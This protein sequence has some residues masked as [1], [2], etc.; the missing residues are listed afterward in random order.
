MVWSFPGGRAEHESAVLFLQASLQ[1]KVVSVMKE[2]CSEA[3]ERGSA[4]SAAKERPFDLVWHL[5]PPHSIELSP[6]AICSPYPLINFSTHAWQDTQCP[7]SGGKPLSDTLACFSRTF[8]F[9]PSSGDWAGSP[10]F[11]HFYRKPQVSSAQFTSPILLATVCSHS[12]AVPFSS[13]L[14]SKTSS[15]KSVIPQERSTFWNILITLVQPV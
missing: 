3:R 14:F 8:D 2:K 7:E 10:I 13:K 15:S 4:N 9:R 6:S 12:S 5:L 11:R 1:S